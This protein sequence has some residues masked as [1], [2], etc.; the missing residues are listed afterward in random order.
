MPIVIVVVM[1]YLVKQYLDCVCETSL[2]KT[3]P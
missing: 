2:I 3:C 1:Q